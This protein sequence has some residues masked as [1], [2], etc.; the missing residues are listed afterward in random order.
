MDFAEWKTRRRAILCAALVFAAGAV[1]AWTL[2]GAEPGSRADWVAAGGT[3]VI[4]AAA[5][6]LTLQAAEA[7]K[8]AQQSVK[9]S[10]LRAMRIQTVAI[11]NLTSRLL[12]LP[13]SGAAVSRV[14]P[15]A[16]A[17]EL[18]CMAIRL[19]LTVVDG[20]DELEEIISDVEFCALAVASL[21]NHFN[22]ESHLPAVGIATNENYNWLRASTKDLQGQMERLRSALTERIAQ[23]S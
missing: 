15:V 1:S 20:D 8:V 13:E 22:A 23:Q 2:I 5:C 6:A 16:G 9:R 3:W 21:A 18:K 19:D 17:L 14:R 10:Q 7:S 11:A 12:A 4:G